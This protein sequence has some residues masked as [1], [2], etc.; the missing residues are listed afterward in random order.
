M[1]RCYQVCKLIFPGLLVMKSI[2]TASSFGRQVTATVAVALTTFGFG[3]TAGAATPEQM[4]RGQQ[5]FTQEFTTAPLTE[6]GDGLGPLFNHT[7]CA[8]CHHAGE[9]GGAGD[10][11]FNARTFAISS[12]DFDQTKTKSSFPEAMKT[13]ALG[14]VSSDGSVLNTFSMH[15]RGGS[16]G[17]DAVRQT[18]M[19]EFNPHWNDDATVC[20][21]DIHQ[22]AAARHWG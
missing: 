9:I 3:G 8:A 16:S 21:D 18:A 15:R 1:L 2:P 10:H 14:F 12:M 6:N 17:F 11:R 4:L 5:L 20:S 19:S 7:S 13:V 22:E